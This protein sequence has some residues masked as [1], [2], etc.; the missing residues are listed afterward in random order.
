VQ[1][2][3]EAE[4]DK[5]SDNWQR[6]SDHLP[7]QK[8]QTLLAERTGQTIDRSVQ[9]DAVQ[10]L[11]K[12]YDL[13]AEAGLER[14]ARA[15]QKCRYLTALIPILLVLLAALSPTIYQIGQGDI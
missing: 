12:L 6:W 10:S 11:Q 14:R 13:R 3:Y 15:A 2:E 5:R 8:L 9:L 1:L 4:R 7:P